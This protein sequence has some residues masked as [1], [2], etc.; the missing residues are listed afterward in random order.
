VNPVSD[1]SGSR[2][3]NTIA[4]AGPELIWIGPVEGDPFCQACQGVYTVHC[5][6]SAYEALA[7]VLTG[8]TAG[9]IVI[10]V[11]A[12]DT[13]LERFCHYLAEVSRFEKAFLYSLPKGAVAY[14]NGT[15][16]GIRQEWVETPAQLLEHLGELTGSAVPED[17]PTASDGS[18]SSRLRDGHSQAGAE[19]V[20]RAARS[21]NRSWPNEPPG[22]KANLL[23]A[24]ENR[25]K[26]LPEQTE[27][28]GQWPP[29]KTSGNKKSFKP[30]TLTDEE[31]RALLGPE[32][33]DEA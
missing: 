20:T 6:E 31:L 19:T 3:A 11:R 24:T 14:S 7:D 13:S 18:E 2:N 9:A 25:T 16:S 5:F 27:D 22:E 17:R 15:A 23:D 29:V 12:I 10:N 21:D 33:D 28:K 32:A 8:R 4:S 26:T 30:A 1:N